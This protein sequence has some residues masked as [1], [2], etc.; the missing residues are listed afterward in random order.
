MKSHHFVTHKAAHVQRD[1]KWLK[2][3]EEKYA[4]W[5]K[6]KT[7][8][9][10]VWN[11]CNKMQHVENIKKT[12]LISFAKKNYKIVPCDVETNCH[13]N[14]S[15]KYLPHETRN[16]CVCNPGFAGNGYDCV[17]LSKDVSCLIV[18]VRNASRNV[19][20]VYAQFICFYR[21]IIAA[22]MRNACTTCQSE[23]LFANVTKI[24]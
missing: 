21:T 2:L 18:S 5:S 1:T 11:F 22:K 16:I 14:A 10:N 24:T 17:E 19:Y 3:W 4:A 6:R 23:N 7:T 12:D 9:K 8:M 20:D 15:C 13:Q